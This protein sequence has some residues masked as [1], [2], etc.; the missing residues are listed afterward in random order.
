M[1]IR[2][3]GT[4]AAEGIPAFY[5]NTS[6]SHY[7]RDNGGKD[8]R[9]RSGA[10][11]DGIIKID[12][13]PDTL[14]HMIRDRLDAREWSALV[15]THS[16]DDHFAPAELQ[17]CLYPFNDMDYLTFTI[18]GNDGICPRIH[19]L[20][21]AWPMD[22]IRTQ[23]FVPFKHQKYTITPIHANHKLDEDAHNLIFQHNGKT[24][25]YGTDT[26]VWFEET[27]EFLKGFALDL[28]V[29]EC[30]EGFRCTDY[31]GHLDMESCL[32]VVDR[33]HKQGT[34]NSGSTIVTTHHSHNGEAT[35][36]QLVDAFAPHGIHVGFDGLEVTV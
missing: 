5:S 13:C 23:S 24:L 2:L 22:I 6:V 32:E 26:G 12:L 35:H 29:I 4:G 14:L 27:W 33:L 36:E 18:Y 34:L 11:I 15:F 9:T 25:L 8:I 3:L 17:Y 1:T 16:H 28:L 30:T 10:L 7:A 31:D 21:P 19:E 20:Y